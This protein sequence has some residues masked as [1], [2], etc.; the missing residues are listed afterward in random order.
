LAILYQ[1]DDFCK[2]YLGGVK[3]VLGS[4]RYAKVTMASYEPTDATIDS[5]ITSL[6]ASGADTL[7]VVAAPKFAAQ[8]IRKVHDLGWKPLFFMSNVSVSVGA[9]ITPT[10]PE[11]AISMLTGTYLK[12][13]TDPQWNNDPGMKEWRAFMNKYLPGA[14]QTDGNYIAAYADRDTMLNVLKMRN[15][16]FSRENVMKTATNL[17][18]LDNPLLLPGLNINT[19]PTNYH[20]IT[21]MQLARWNGKTWEL[22]GPLIRGSAL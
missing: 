10:G 15:G 1:N 20:P 2:Y 17:H 5:Q 7:L 11:N 3:T 13:P 4:A 8:A 22:F 6:Q 9:V 12:D 14:D 19:S 18:D 21:A 16:N